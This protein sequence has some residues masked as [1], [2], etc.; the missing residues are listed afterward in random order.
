MRYPVSPPLGSRLAMVSDMSPSSVHMVSATPSQ[1]PGAWSALRTFPRCVVVCC[2]G[3]LSS[4]EF[5]QQM[6]EQVARMDDKR[7]ASFLSQ[8][9]L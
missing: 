7:A 1:P 9:L 4:E 5:Q 3:A 6:H 8:H 2:C